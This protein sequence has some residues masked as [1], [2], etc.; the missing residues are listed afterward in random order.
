MRFYI[1]GMYVMIMS[2]SFVKGQ[3][4]GQITDTFGNPLAFAAIYLKGSTKGTNSNLEGNYELSLGIGRQ[5][6]IYHY[7]GFQTLEIEIEYLGQPVVLNIKLK[8]S[9]YALQEIFVSSNQEDPANAIIRKAIS[10]RR[11]YLNQLP[12]YTCNAYTKGFIKI[13]E[14]PKKIFGQ[15]IGTMNGNLDT[16]R[17]G[18]IYLSETVSKL[19]FQKPDHLYEEMIS[20]IISGRDNGFSF[21]SA[22][23][24]SFNLYENT[25]EFGKS[26]VSPIAD[27]AF[28]YYKFKLLGTDTIHEARDILHRIQVI[29]KN[30]S[31]GC[32]NGEIYIREGDWSIHSLNLFITGK[33]VHQE[34]FDTI[35]LQQLFIPMKEDGLYKIQN[36]LFGF[37]ANLLGIK[38]AGNFVVVFSDYLLD[39]RI[40]IESK[41]IVLTVKDGANEKGAIYWDSIR[42]VPLTLDEK[43]DYQLK[44]SI[45][46]IRE[47][48][49]YKDSL[50]RKNNRFKIADLL[51]GYNYSNSYQRWKITL[52]SPLE[53]LHFNPVTGWSLGTKLRYIRFLNKNNPCARIVANLSLDYG[54]SDKRFRPSFLWQ[55]HFNNPNKS[56][57]ELKGGISL[58]EFHS[59]NSSKIL[60]EI[61]NLLFKKNLVKYFDKKYFSIGAGLDIS[62][63]INFRSSIEY[64][65]RRNVVNDSEY[66]L[67]NKSSVYQENSKADQFE[68]ILKV[69]HRDHISWKSHL[70][71]SPGTK[72]W[73]T[74]NEI[75]KIG[76]VYPQFEFNYRLGI[77]TQ[78]MQSYHNLGVTIGKNFNFENAG[79][80][81][82]SLKGNALIYK[83]EVD[84]PERIFQH[85]NGLSVYFKPNDNNYFLS[86]NPYAYSS[87]K[88]C[89]SWHV[90]HD[91]HGLILERIPLI[92]RLGFKE[93]LRLSSVSIPGSTPFYEASFGLGNVGYKL[94]RFFRIDWVNQF[95][96]GEFKAAYLKL[97][98][99]STLGAGD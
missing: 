99:I 44:D 93:L 84:I 87:A 47:T 60:H 90:E 41:N 48:K 15:E 11:Y 57:I 39:E 69:S 73:I 42:P 18:F 30:N 22:S 70:T 81:S 36:Q 8:P 29:P 27:Y 13:L 33:Q 55:N 31:L 52:G 83:H 78:S 20:S 66:S 96:H 65:Q 35:Y 1:L 2:A 9:V 97:G 45:K 63:D 67:R 92:N 19:T 94:F 10:K 53:L 89:I 21:N 76:T 38:I 43:S 16:N 82:I 88:Q 68:N 95:Y 72:V 25:S 98:L 56:Y 75:I 71:W 85:G 23:S 74:P 6:L 61:N 51:L 28:S 91:F 37:K 14:A 46:G 26:I 64:S 34:L 62:Y 24:V 40:A 5:K 77:Y 86:M 49:F 4:K 54:F 3:V 12:N 7:L 50:D 58:V 32:W 80:L 17:K 59:F 79:D